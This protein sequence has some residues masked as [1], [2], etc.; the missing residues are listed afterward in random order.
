MFTS[1]WQAFEN[2]YVRISSVGTSS[3]LDLHEVICSSNDLTKTQLVNWSTH[4]KTTWVLYETKE[5]DGVLPS[6]GMEFWA[7]MRSKI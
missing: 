4:R 2:L 3:D 1:V 6:G 7:C 5:K